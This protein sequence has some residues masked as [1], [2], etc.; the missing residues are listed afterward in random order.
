MT[1]SSINVDKRSTDGTFKQHLVEDVKMFWP[2]P[3]ARTGW[4]KWKRKITVIIM[5]K[6]TKLAYA[7]PENSGKNDLY[8]HLNCTHLL[9]CGVDLAVLQQ[10]ADIQLCLVW[11]GSCRYGCCSTRTQRHLEVFR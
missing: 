7:H 11:I 2:V 3:A 8:N 5:A 4:N 9:K 6:E 10:F 1:G